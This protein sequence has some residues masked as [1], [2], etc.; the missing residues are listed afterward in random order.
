MA[1]IEIEMITTIEMQC[2]NCYHHSIKHNNNDNT[3]N[4]S[5]NHS[6]LA[7]LFGTHCHPMIWNTS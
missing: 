4:H 2:Q 7:T 5:N 1:Q 6:T 3:I